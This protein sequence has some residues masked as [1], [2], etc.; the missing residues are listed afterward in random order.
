MAHQIADRDIQAGIEMAWH[1]LTK[2]VPVVTFEDAFPFDIERLPLHTQDGTPLEGWSYFRCSDDG[3]P[4][5]VPV[6]ESYSALTNARFWEIVQNAVGGSGAVIESAGSIYDRCRRFVTVKLGTDVDDFKVG[7][8]VF[9]NRFSLLDSIDG[10][11]NFY[12]INSSTCV[13]C[14]NT[15]AVVMGDTSGEFRF[16]LRHSKNLLPR[17]ENME[18][19][20]DCFVGVTAQFQKA[21]VIANEI[22]VSVPDARSLF[23]G[24]AGQESNALSTRTNNTVNR[25]T[26]LFQTGAGN[27][28]Q[29]LLD[30]FSAVTDFYSHES[31]G[32]ADQPNFRMKQNL[33]SE[34]GS[35]SRKKQDFFA[36]VFNVSPKKD[37]TFNRSGFD[38]LVN[39]G[40][41]LLAASD[42]LVTAN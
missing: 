42:A 20:I 23:A 37:P 18:K 32:G 17:I 30:A 7:E 5:G 38:S 11:T 22:P 2:V 15:F 21:L 6:S 39:N 25:L 31:S 27:R 35:G 28:G 33:S 12:G 24:W 36:N 13:V 14:A 9:K 29:T 40:R 10:S 4:A 3:K 41:S 34:F 26:D 1:G 8:R 19:A 16:K